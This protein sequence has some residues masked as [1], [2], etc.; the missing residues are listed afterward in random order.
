MEGLEENDRLIRNYTKTLRSKIVEVWE[1]EDQDGN[2]YKIC[3]DQDGGEWV[4]E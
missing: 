2:T 4:E 3:Q 1:F